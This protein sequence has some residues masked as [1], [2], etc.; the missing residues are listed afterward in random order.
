MSQIQITVIEPNGVQRTRP[1]T[2]R[3]MTIGRASTNDLLI[4]YDLVSR[5]H[6]QVFFD[7]GHY[8]VVD[9]DSAN[10][11]Y[12]GQERLPPNKPALW[13]PGQ[14]LHI[15]GVIIHLGQRQAEQEQPQPRPGGEFGASSGRRRRDREETYT[16]LPGTVSSQP[17]SS[18]ATGRIVLVVALVLFVLC[19]C[20]AAGVG[21]YFFLLAG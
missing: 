10:G 21:G 3:G 8:Y 19:V 4:S 12:L 1:L 7:Q 16:G 9:L 5:H 14:P 2:T 11:T 20:S 18:W 6:A 15:A 17:A 13:M